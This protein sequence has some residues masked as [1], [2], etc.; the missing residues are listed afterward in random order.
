MPIYV[1][2]PTPEAISKA[3]ECCTF[4]TLQSMSEAPLNMCPTCGNPVHRILAGFAVTHKNKPVPAGAQLFSKSSD[5]P[6]S[7]V[8]KSAM[9]HVCSLGCRH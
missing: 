7:R 2:E 4:E 6:A 5:T 9:G 8:A 1:Y 3:S